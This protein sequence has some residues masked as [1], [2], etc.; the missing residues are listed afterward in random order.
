MQASVRAKTASEDTQDMEMTDNAAIDADNTDNAAIDADNTDNAETDGENTD[1]AAM[2]DNNTDNV[3]T[4][5]GSTD[6]AI[7]GEVSTVYIPLP[8]RY[9]G[10]TKDP[11]QI[12]T[13]SR[14]TPAIAEPS[15]GD[16]LPDGHDTMKASHNKVDLTDVF[17]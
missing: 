14:H 11:S 16:P 3:I 15:T 2:S 4:G 5:N 12:K 13:S 1:D 6:N 9:S 10:K 7:T 8:P 17:I